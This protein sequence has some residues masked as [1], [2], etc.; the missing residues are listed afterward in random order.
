MGIKQW[1]VKEGLD[2]KRV[3]RGGGISDVLDG[4]GRRSQTSVGC[5][6]KGLSRVYVTGGRERTL[7]SSRVPKPCVSRTD[8][9]G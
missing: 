4:D 1:L 9:V 2:K 5:Q 7:C 6:E 8:P 3:S